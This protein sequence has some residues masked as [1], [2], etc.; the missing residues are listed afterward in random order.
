MLR[1]ARGGLGGVYDRE[2]AAVRDAAR[3]LSGTRDVD[4]MIATLQGL[5]D[6]DDTQIDSEA[7]A[8][9]VAELRQLGSPQT[10][11]ANDDARGRLAEFR[12]AFAAL[13]DRTNTWK[14]KGGGVA[15]LAD[16]FAATYGK[17]RDAMGAAY[18]H[19]TPERFH[20]WRK[21]AKYHW[22]HLQLLRRIW[23]PVMKTLD[24]QAS[25]LADLLGADHD[26]AV[27][28][29]RLEEISTDESLRRALIAAAEARRTE[30]QNA[31]RI[32][33]ARLFL[34]KPA[35]WNRTVR[36]LWKRRG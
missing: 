2:N 33:G 1:L 16:G 14:I 15:T 4:V 27:L 24:S 20:E 3:L 36:K 30:L 35:A 29:V 10:N 22:Y 34:A 13:S 11:A 17:A 12:A 6:G 19:P 7:V 21:H 8:A 9:I 25:E 5:L 28:A 26:L 31:A 18:A 23:P 32:L